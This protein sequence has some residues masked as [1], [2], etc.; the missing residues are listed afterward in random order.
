ML[1]AAKQA[2]PPPAHRPPHCLPLL[3]DI[4]EDVTQLCRWLHALAAVGLRPPDATLR[5]ACS[6]LRHHRRALWRKEKLWLAD[7]F[8]EWGVR[9]HGLGP[10]GSG[11][12]GDE[13]AG[14]GGGTAEEK[15]EQQ[16]H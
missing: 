10:L 15:L 6:Y 14:S 2:C 5:S 11:G 1:S 3:Q 16:Q 8:Q 7:A 9:G 4:R 13:G 12:G